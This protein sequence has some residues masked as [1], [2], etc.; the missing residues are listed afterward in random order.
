MKESVGGD[1]VTVRNEKEGGVDEPNGD[2]DLKKV[3]KDFR[4]YCFAAMCLGQEEHHQNRGAIKAIDQ[5][6]SRFRHRQ[7][8]EYS[9]MR[10]N[11]GGNQQD[12]DYDGKQEPEKT[13]N[14]T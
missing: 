3:E 14:T 1:H 11:G 6:P 9:V 4:T 8:T 13:R 10:L 7:S 12:C 2:C 5:S